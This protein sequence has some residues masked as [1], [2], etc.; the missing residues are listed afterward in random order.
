MV[1]SKLALLAAIDTLTEFHR[2]YLQAN[3]AVSLDYVAFPCARVYFE[4]GIV[5]TNRN[6]LLKIIR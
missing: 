6:Y 2:R 1:T 4:G 3:L 5:V